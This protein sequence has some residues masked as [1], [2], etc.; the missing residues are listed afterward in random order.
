MEI[1]V[2]EGYMFLEGVGWGMVKK[3]RYLF[4]VLPLIAVI[5]AA[6]G[7]GTDGRQGES[8]PVMTSE[9]TVGNS[10][11]ITLTFL[12]PS[13]GRSK[14]WF[15]EPFGDAIEKKFPNI[16]VNFVFGTKVNDKYY[17]LP[18]M[19]V[20]GENNIDVLMTSVGSFIPNVLD[21]GLQYD[22]SGLIKQNN[23]DLSKLENGPIDLMRQISGG[24]LYGLPVS[25]STATLI[26]NR[27]IF[28]KF[29]VAYPKNGMSW[30]ET[31]ELARKVTRTDNGKAY[32]G[33]V[34]SFEHLALTN[35]LSA[36]YIDPKTNK[37]MF[38]SDDKWA[39]HSQNFQRFFQ[40]PGN[41]VDDK[42]ITLSSMHKAFTVDQTAAMYVNAFDPSI[43]NPGP[44]KLDLDA[45][46][47][48]QYS[49]LPGVGS[50]L[51]PSYFS[52]TNM[53]K[54]KEEAFQVIAWLTGDEFQ[55]ERAKKG[56]LPVVKSPSVR[57]ALGQD[58]VYLKGRNAKA[59]LPEKAAS[60]SLQSKF[61]R[62]ADVEFQSQIYTYVLGKVDLNTMLR[63]TTEEVN[64]KIAAQT[65]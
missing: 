28:D 55:M 12:E 18:E 14:E 11:P 13:T 44:D 39:K 4:I 61:N 47:L 34:V 10:E 6:C 26:Y 46:T 35:Q 42:T 56:F 45:V 64:K 15:M 65:P 59:F 48:P 50:Q 22:M 52:V 60:P 20:A 49:D 32:R 19:L 43:L 24:G 2:N 7:N 16:K 62:T 3:N 29:G 54:H 23:Y 17:G 57:N 53:S 25:A 37:A 33:F 9:K 41:E 5:L 30:D 63:T 51:Y 21:N 27:A 40:I 38:N 8:S 36:S 1:C 58:V 31:Y